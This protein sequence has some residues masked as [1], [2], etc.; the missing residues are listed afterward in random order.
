MS[1]RLHGKR[2]IGPA[3]SQASEPTSVSGFEGLAPPF[4]Y[5]EPDLLPLNCSA[6]DAQ[7]SQD[8]SAT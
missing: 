5:P 3:F 2:S 7:S 4:L 6:F 8:L 1:T